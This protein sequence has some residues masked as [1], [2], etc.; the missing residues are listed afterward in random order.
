MGLQKNVV[1]LVLVGGQD[2]KVDP[3]LA[4]RPRELVNTRYAFE[5]SISKRYGSECLTPKQGAQNNRL[6][7][8]PATDNPRKTYGPEHGVP[9]NLVSSKGELLRCSRG[10][11]DRVILPVELQKDGGSPYAFGPLLATD[12][13]PNH[14][15]TQEGYA[16]QSDMPSQAD[17]YGDYLATLVQRGATLLLGIRNSTTLVALAA[18][19][20]TASGLAFSVDGTVPARVVVAPDAATGHVFAT[21]YYVDTG[22]VLRFVAFD[23]TDSILGTAGIVVT[24]V[25]RFDV[26][27]GVRES[28]SGTGL[29]TSWLAWIDFAIGTDQLHVATVRKGAKGTTVSFGG[30]LHPTI[31]GVDS[32]AAGDYVHVGAAEGGII[33]GWGFN[34]APTPTLSWGPVALDVTADAAA[35][36]MEALAVKSLGPFGEYAAWLFSL[37]N[38]PSTMTGGEPYVATWWCATDS[39]GVVVEQAST[40]SHF[41]NVVLTS[42]PWVDASEV[43]YAIAT[44]ADYLAPCTYTIVRLAPFATEPATLPASNGPLGEYDAFF[45]PALARYPLRRPN[46]VFPVSGAIVQ[47]APRTVLDRAA[48]G[49]TVTAVT[50]ILPRGT[51][52]DPRDTDSWPVALYTFTPVSSYGACEGL[53]DY[54]LSA[55]AIL[56]YDGDRCFEVTPS[57]RAY[58]YPIDAETT[59]GTGGL[60]EGARYGI[61]FCLAYRDVRGV[62]HRSAPS[63]A[64][65][66]TIT[67]TTADT[68]TLKNTDRGILP[69]RLFSTYNGVGYSAYSIEVYR[70]E[71]NGATFYLERAFPLTA[72]LSAG[73]LSD[74]DLRTQPVLYTTSAALEHACPPPARYAVLAMGRVF[75]LGTEDDFVWPSD[76]LFQGEAPTWNAI[77]SFPVPG[78]GAITGGAELDLALIVFRQNAIYAVTGDGPSSAGDGG[79]QIQPVATD[80]GCV[81]ARSIVNVPDGVLFQSRDGIAI[82]TRALSVERVGKPV[83]LFLSGV[84]AEDSAGIS[85]AVNVPTETEARFA[86]QRYD[87]APKRTEAAVCYRLAGMQAAAWS[88]STWSTH[89]VTG[90]MRV[91]AACLYAN[92]YTW[93]TDNGYILQETPG[94]YLDGFTSGALPQYVPMTAWLA[95]W[96]PGPVQGWAR[97]WRVGLLGERK[98]AHDLLVELFHDYEDSPSTTRSWTG[99]EIAA[100]SVEQL[101]VHV[102]KQKAEAIAVRVRDI[103]PTDAATLTGEGLVLA[104]VSLEMGMKSGM[105]RRPAVQKR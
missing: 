71:A 10:A 34:A 1:D 62:L 69:S 21:T 91:V 78:L 2:D 66:H 43:V 52:V 54:V 90:G 32:K 97:I 53:E 88:E 105:H 70:T 39:S 14:H 79:F 102:V 33:Q 11:I 51:N 75:L 99:A 57:A 77:T 48:E 49:G 68:L 74:E 61:L 27:P 96:K 55:G 3:R 76:V 93:I 20:L 36:C 16:V 23:C 40:S 46:D 50:A 12:T 13:L 60:A 73:V 103:A 63:D 29:D 82:L 47:V 6:V 59:T 100:L 25:L 87:G 38:V 30:S 101:K 89:G 31:V 98:D 37:N 86:V 8:F 4:V 45:S 94:A 64:T 5:G 18:S 67:G 84:T 81:D 92:R 15:V 58:A 56:S 28:G 9:C 85:A 7:E 83:E 65:F 44:F 35:T 42:K 104:G 41:R 17:A 26:T 80:I 72:A 24:N 19:D 95:A 22:H